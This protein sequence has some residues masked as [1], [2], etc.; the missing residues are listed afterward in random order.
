MPGVSTFNEP[1]DPDACTSVD[2]LIAGLRLLKAWGGDPSYGTIARRVN[3][4]WSAAGRPERTTKNTVADCFSIGRARPSEDLVLAA[5][6]ALHPDPG[7][8][9]RWRQA[10]RVVRG[11]AVAASFVRA[12]DRPPDDLAGFTGRDD[13]I[14][15]LRHHL[16]SAPSGGAGPMVIA[17]MAGVGKTQLAVH[18]AHL[19]VRE[20]VFDR[21]L[22]V[23]LR[24]FHPS[25]AQ[26]PADPAAVLDAFL[27]LLGVAAH[28]I[29]HR[30]DQRIRLYREQLGGRQV[31]TVL[32][33]AAS[34]HQ[35]QPLLSTL[36]GCLTVV[37]SRASLGGLPGAA[38]LCLDVFSPGDAVELLRAAAGEQ[39]FAAE[40]EVAA[41]IAQLLG[42]LP[43]ALGLTAGRIR[44][45]AGWTLTDHLER[46]VDRGDPAPDVR[47]AV[48]RLLA[49]PSRLATSVRLENPVSLALDLSYDRLGPRPARTFRLLALHPGIDVDPY[50]A[51]ALGDL[52]LDTARR[53]RGRVPGA[54]LLP[55]RAPARYELPALARAW[56]WTRAGAA[57]R[58]SERRAARARLLNSQGH[59]AG[60]AMDQYAAPGGHRRPTLPRPPSPV[61]ELAGREAAVAWLD[62]E[63]TNLVAV[64]VHAA[65]H[66]RADYTAALS[67]V[68]YR[69]LDTHGHQHDALILHTRACRVDDPAVRAR[70]LLNLGVTHWRLGRNHDAIERL[71]QALALYRQ[72][73]DGAGECDALSNLGVVHER[74]G[75]Y[76]EALEHDRRALE[77]YRR[78]GDRHGE[79][80]AVSNLG[81][82]CSK[83]GRYQEALQHLRSGLEAFRAVGDRINEGRMLGNLADA[84]WRHGL[85]SE[86]AG[87]AADALTVAEEVGNRTGQ[88][89]AV[90]ILGDLHQR[91]GDYPRALEYHRRALGIYR[92]VGNRD[93]QVE[94]LNGIGE[95]LRHT[96]RP[97]LAADHHARALAQAADLGDRREQ[98]RA[99][100]GLAHARQDLGDADGARRHWR[101]ALDLYTELGSPEAARV[102]SRL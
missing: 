24:G 87:Y 99:H 20:G 15:S 41:L 94:A 33:N 55:G 90:G 68:L 11:E 100:D 97:D 45:D 98:A 6:E 48:A 2:D 5:V 85:D 42:Y 32:D 77:G 37:T 8:V 7:Y 63:R 82:V 43:L 62:T 83:L 101:L 71:R 92:S 57:D 4:R 78:V 88:A 69:Y 21:V 54:N 96:G 27:R 61:P 36:P 1:P 60:R 28:A 31:L 30:L 75:R 81:I 64:A 35:V 65:D 38:Q 51:A 26:P 76:Q 58:G 10:F 34:E 49:D 59:P 66:G 50:A 73:G 12:H 25:P 72:V 89:A 91:R 47:D 53:H 22:F 70:T 52:D 79:G 40:P 18:A 16:E 56:G 86:A 9:S 17:G 46:L 84:C 14:K 19:F 93:G 80:F 3:A 29:P 23:D 74:L 102:T 39:R 13:E 95:S 67:R 44:T